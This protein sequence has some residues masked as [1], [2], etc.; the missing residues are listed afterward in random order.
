MCSTCCILHRREPTTP[1]RIPCK[2]LSKSLPVGVNTARKEPKTCPRQVAG[3]FCSPDF[4]LL[5]PL[6]YGDCVHHLFAMQ[7]RARVDW[8]VR[9]IVN[10]R[11]PKRKR[12]AV[13]TP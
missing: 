8:T 2:K 1:P 13:G 7:E 12:P 6:Q 5:L 9:S 3:R 4:P 11:A 10:C